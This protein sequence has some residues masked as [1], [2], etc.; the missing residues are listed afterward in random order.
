MSWLGG[1]EKLFIKPTFRGLP[2]RFRFRAQTA[3]LFAATSGFGCNGFLHRGRRNRKRKLLEEFSRY[4][5]VSC[6]SGERIPRDLA[7]RRLRNEL[8]NVLRRHPVTQRAQ[9]VK[10]RGPKA[11]FIREPSRN[12]RFSVLHARS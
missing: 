6:G 8:M 11:D 4:A 3:R 2:L 7:K 10:L 1:A 5:L 9:D 12:A